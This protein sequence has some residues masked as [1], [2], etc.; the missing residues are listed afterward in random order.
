MVVFIWTQCH[1]VHL[2]HSQPF[3]PPFD[4]LP[5]AFS[6]WAVRLQ[7]EGLPK[8]KFHLGRLTPGSFTWALPWDRGPPAEVFKELE[9]ESGLNLAASTDLTGN[10]SA[11]GN[12]L[13]ETD[14]VN[15]KDGRGCGH[16]RTWSCD[17]T[18]LD[19]VDSLEGRAQKKQLHSWIARHRLGD[20]PIFDV[21]PEMPHFQFP[22]TCRD[23]Y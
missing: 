3:L 8:S 14:G 4:R 9:S 20:E 6:S 2:P 15:V 1:H 22:E 17:M 21:I 12:W 13:L 16:P 19:V 18:S 7:E 23:D 10:K 5:F 11:G